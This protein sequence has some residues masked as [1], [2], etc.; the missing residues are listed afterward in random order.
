MVFYTSMYKICDSMG[1]PFVPFMGCVCLWTGLQFVVIACSGLSELI[2]IVTRFTNEIFACLIAIIYLSIAVDEMINQYEDSPL[3]AA[4]TSALLSFGTAWLCLE[5]HFARDWRILTP[6]TREFLASYNTFIC[7]LVF[8][9]MSYWGK[10]EEAGVKRLQIPETWSGISNDG[11]AGGITGK[12]GQPVLEVW[13]VFFAFVPGFVLMLLYFFDHQVCA[14]LSQPKEFNLKKPSS[15]HW[16]LI[17][18]GINVAVAGI[19]GIPPTNCVL[20]QSPV[21][22]Y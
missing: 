16:D 9:G 4:S 8:T 22:V 10:L 5:L 11:L 6:S 3:A 18:L 21:C 12:N 7:T 15:Y 2:E 1:M 19:L 17:V 20:P 13:H 14:L